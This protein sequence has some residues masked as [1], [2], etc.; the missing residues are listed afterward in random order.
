MKELKDYQEMAFN[1]PVVKG[2]ID[3]IEEIMD[4][5]ARDGFTSATLGIDISK[6]EVKLRISTAIDYFES[7]GFACTGFLVKNNSTL[8]EV[9]ISWKVS[10]KD[11]D[12]RITQFVGC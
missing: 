9:T 12:R 10:D 3:E 1:H 11:Y 8:V 2:L 7:R 4:K 6:E 5:S